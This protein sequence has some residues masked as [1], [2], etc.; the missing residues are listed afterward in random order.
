MSMKEF[1]TNDEL[2]LAKDCDKELADC[3]VMKNI[4]LMNFHHKIYGNAVKVTVF[5]KQERK[6][7]FQTI[8]ANCSRQRD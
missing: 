2:A 1:W 3:P 8:C 4:L 7:S 6:K 5:Y